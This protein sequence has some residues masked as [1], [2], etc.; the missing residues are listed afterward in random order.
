MK[1]ITLKSDGLS[2]EYLPPGLNLSKCSLVDLD[3]TIN[4]IAHFNL[5]IHIPKKGTPYDPQFMNAPVAMRIVNQVDSWAIFDREK[6]I[7]LRKALV[8]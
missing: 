3:K 8:K 7:A 6:G 4:S 1:S 2:F 5:E